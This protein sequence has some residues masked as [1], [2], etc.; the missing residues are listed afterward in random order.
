M[1]VNLAYSYICIYCT[2]QSHSTYLSISPPPAD[3]VSPKQS[4]ILLPANASFIILK[5]PKLPDWR[6]P[7]QQGRVAR[8]ALLGARNKRFEK[9]RREREREREQERLG[10]GFDESNSAK[11]D[12]R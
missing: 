12:T 11:F 4:V 7:T 10:I 9:E 6:Y 1:S 2:V 3:R 5:K 8:G